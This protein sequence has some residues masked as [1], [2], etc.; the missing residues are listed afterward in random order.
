MTPAM[1]RIPRASDTAIR[2]L[3]TGTTPKR[4]GHRRRA[5]FTGGN[6]E[7]VCIPCAL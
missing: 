1:H 6:L 4:P 3:A 5:G 2:A 7:G